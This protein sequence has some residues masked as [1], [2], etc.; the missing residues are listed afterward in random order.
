MAQHG[1]LTSVAQMISFA[2]L[3]FCSEYTLVLV[4]GDYLMAIEFFAIGLLTQPET[5]C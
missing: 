2:F 4:G 5:R 1:R 3:D